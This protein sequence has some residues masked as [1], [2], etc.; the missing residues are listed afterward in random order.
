MRQRPRL[1]VWLVAIVLLLSG[2]GSYGS[3]D[4]VAGPG[5]SLKQ[6]GKTLTTQDRL[7]CKASKAYARDSLVDLMHPDVV[8]IRW[9][10]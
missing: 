4:T 9:L 7:A 6:F 2:S 5:R 10:V 1:R 3:V 8:V